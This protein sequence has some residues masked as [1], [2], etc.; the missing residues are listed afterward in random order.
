[1]SFWIWIFVLVLAIVGAS[2]AVGAA[3]SRRRPRVNPR[4]DKMTA[5]K[6]SGAFPH[7]K[8]NRP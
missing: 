5:L 1:M 3:L 8:S 2:V 7:R 6:A 4:D